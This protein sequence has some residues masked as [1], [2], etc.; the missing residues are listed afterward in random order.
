MF[1]ILKD[2]L[3]Y[4]I[5]VL[6]YVENLKYN[7]YYYMLNIYFIYDMGMSNIII[8]CVIYLKMNYLCCVLGFLDGI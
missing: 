1:K 8:N 6:K 4:F 5:L 3:F 2:V 7:I